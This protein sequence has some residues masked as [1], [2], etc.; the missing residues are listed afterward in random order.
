MKHYFFQ[1]DLDHLK[2]ELYI[3]DI[4]KRFDLLS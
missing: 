3:L 4:K 2:V 1:M